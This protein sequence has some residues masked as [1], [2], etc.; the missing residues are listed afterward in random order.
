MRG[1]FIWN[2]ETIGMDFGTLKRL[3]ARIPNAHCRERGGTL[4]SISAN[5]KSVN[6]IDKSS[7]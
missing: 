1:F 4:L 6:P 5:F 7:N 2:E 3:S